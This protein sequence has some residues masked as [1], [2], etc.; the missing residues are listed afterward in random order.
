MFDYEWAP[1]ENSK[2]SRNRPAIGPVLPIGDIYVATEWFRYL[3]DGTSYKRAMMWQ[4]LPAMTPM[5]AE[6]NNS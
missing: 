5:L 3:P 6:V 1:F 2:N 4:N